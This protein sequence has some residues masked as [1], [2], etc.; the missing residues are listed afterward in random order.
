MI[1]QTSLNLNQKEDG[2]N[3]FEVKSKRGSINESE[4]EL[5]EGSIK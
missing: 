3:E 1:Y 5:K 4:V 2:S